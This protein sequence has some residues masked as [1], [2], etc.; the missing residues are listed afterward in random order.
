MKTYD[1]HSQDVK[2]AKKTLKTII[3]DLKQAEFKYS[4]A[5]ITGQGVHARNKIPVLRMLAIETLQAH[6]LKFTISES[7]PGVI[8]VVKPRY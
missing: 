3:D 4:I 1:L 8:I 2:T 6:K 7:N 5:I